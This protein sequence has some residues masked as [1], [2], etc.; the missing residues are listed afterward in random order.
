M[1]RPVQRR[2]R[3]GDQGR[4][5]PAVPR[6]HRDPDAEPDREGVVVDREILVEHMLEP[7]DQVGDARRIERR[8]CDEFVA[9]DPRQEGARAD[10]AQASR[11]F[12]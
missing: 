1:L 10:V 8:D 2:V 9:A 7:F 11:H 12:A 5:V 6:V 3:V 4:R